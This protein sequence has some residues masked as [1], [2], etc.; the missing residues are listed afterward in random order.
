MRIANGERNRQPPARSYGTQS[1]IF[2]PGGEP[3]HR[4][5]LEMYINFL[6][7]ITGSPALQRYEAT[8]GSIAIYIPSPESYRI[9]PLVI[10]GL[11]DSLPPIYLDIHRDQVESSAPSYTTCTDATN[12]LV[13][14][15][16]TRSKSLRLFYV[17]EIQL[18]FLLHASV[19][20]FF[21]FVSLDNNVDRLSLVRRR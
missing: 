2:P 19:I 18:T 9:G 1:P 4:G 21:C 20:F 16:Q 17:D 11:L 8:L 13:R 5:L 14:L 10:P 12:R 3:R 6:Y 15:D 7:P